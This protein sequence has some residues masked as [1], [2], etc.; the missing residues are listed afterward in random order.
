M[1]TMNKL[2]IKWLNAILA[3]VFGISTTA[4]KVMYGVPHADYD[5]AGVVQNEEWKG[6]EGVQVI[7]KSY[8]DF[9]RTDTVYTNAEGTFHDK[10]AADCSSGECLE[11][12]VNDPK[13]E[14]QSDT[15]HIS[16]RRMEVVEDG[17][18]YDAYAIDN[19]YIT[20]KKK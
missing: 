2:W 17:D 11:L 13:G 15:M 14:Y 8:S 6:L 5:V 9:E 10:Y 12:I 20:L 7:I 4:C 3:G 16:N 19:I 1:K 18:W